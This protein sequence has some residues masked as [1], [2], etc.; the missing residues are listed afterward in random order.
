M[1]KKG[2][3]IPETICPQQQI[4]VLKDDPPVR[5][6]VNIAFKFSD[7]SELHI[8]INPRYFFLFLNEIICCDPSL[9]R[10]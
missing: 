4:L 7:L 9:R 2:L 6:G 10:F 8:S 1:Y 3:P 5:R